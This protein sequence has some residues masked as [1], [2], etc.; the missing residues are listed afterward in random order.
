MFCVFGLLVPF[1]SPTL[2]GVFVSKRLKTLYLKPPI[3]FLI[4]SEI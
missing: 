1:L 2:F 4:G 3:L